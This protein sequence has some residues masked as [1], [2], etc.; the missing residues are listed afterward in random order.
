MKIMTSTLLVSGLLSGVFSSSFSLAA[1]APKV[2]LVLSS[3]GEK[4]AQG[5]MIKPGFEMDELSKAYLV[6]KDHGLDIELASP[7]GGKPHADNFNPE[8]SYNQQFLA[9]SNAM[10]KLQNTLALSSIDPADYRSVFVVGGK[11]PMF[12]LAQNQ[13]LQATIRTIYENHGVV[14]A[15]CH[16]PAALTKVKL[17]TGEWLVANKRVSGFSEEEEAAFSKKWA[18]QFPFQ[19]ESMLIEQGATYVQDGLMLNQVSIDGN[20]ITGQ[21]P[22]ST[23]DTVKAMIKALGIELK[24]TPEFQDDATIKLVERYFDNVET[25]SKHFQTHS[26]DY[27]TMLLAMFGYYQAQHAQTE[28]QRNVAIKIMEDTLTAVNHPMLFL[29]LASSYEVNG[30]LSEAKHVLTLA[31]GKFPENQ[32]IVSQLVRY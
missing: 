10:E 23:V 32:D 29:G 13:H 2:L 27:D 25:A 9:D 26:T 22:F 4:N 16:G 17:S 19:L 11:G 7:Q 24:S 18:S 3:Y 5:E 31:Q 15:V 6:F 20:L 14:G 28:Q 8:K 12:D 21:N 30:Q 1:D